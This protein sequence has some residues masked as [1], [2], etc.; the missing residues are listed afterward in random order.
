MDYE[1]VL[2]RWLAGDGIRPIAR[3]T[4]LGRKTVGKYVSIALG[5][6]HQRGGHEASSAAL[7]PGDCRAL[8]RWHNALH[9]AGG[10]R[11]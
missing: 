9:T 5:L 7:V 2:R 8:H 1:E 10:I 11:G 4:R 6:G 3:A